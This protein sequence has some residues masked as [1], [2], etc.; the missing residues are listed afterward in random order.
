MAPSFHGRCP[1]IA[2]AHNQVQRLAWTLSEKTLTA[3][4]LTRLGLAL[5]VGRQYGLDALSQ[6]SVLGNTLF[7]MHLGRAWSSD[8]AFLDSRRGIPAD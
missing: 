1:D 6:G 2:F 7:M 8:H 4:L 5:L 3:S